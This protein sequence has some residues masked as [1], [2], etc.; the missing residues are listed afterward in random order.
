MLKRV[1]VCALHCEAKPLIDFYRLKKTNQKLPFDHFS[2][3]NIDLIISGIGPLNSAS[4]V[5]WFLGRI[6]SHDAEI[7]ILNIGVAGHQSAEIGQLF[8]AC[9]IGSELDS[10]AFY[11]IQWFKHN[12]ELCCLKTG[13]K[14]VTK[15]SQ[16]NLH[17]MEAYGF[18]HAAS[19]F[20]SAE[21]IHSLKVV[22][23]NSKQTFINDKAHISQLI[24]HQIEK[25]DQFIKACGSEVIK[26]G[27][28]SVA[29][30]S[31][32]IVGNTHF[33][34]SQKL[35]LKKYLN[36]FN[37]QN[38]SYKLSQEN[39]SANQILSEMKQQL[40]DQGNKI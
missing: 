35:Q 29:I 6:E 17:D 20:L 32:N 37:V 30:N 31:K 40:F 16:N 12:I 13:I 25:I 8:S 23:D 1:L 14:A 36:S 22:S 10:K 39:I 11:P 28:V 24:A 33:T 18:F 26:P 9:K 4:A 27:L 2:T 3:E 7:L 34:Q 38:L 5:S 19:Q 15:Y 21:W